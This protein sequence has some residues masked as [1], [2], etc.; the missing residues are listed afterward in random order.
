MIRV[1]DVSEKKFEYQ[2][3]FPISASW[4]LNGMRCAIAS[5]WTWISREGFWC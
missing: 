3:E 5:R 4:N 2:R 1:F